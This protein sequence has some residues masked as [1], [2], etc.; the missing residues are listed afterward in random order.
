MK[1]PKKDSIFVLCCVVVLCVSFIFALWIKQGINKMAQAK[2]Y[3]IA[4]VKSKAPVVQR[5][6][7]SWIASEERVME[8]T[9]IDNDNTVRGQFVM[10]DNS[11]LGNIGRGNISTGRGFGRGNVT[12]TSVGATAVDDPSG[13]LLQNVEASGRASRFNLQQG[14]IVISINGQTVTGAESFD[15]LISAIGQGAAISMQVI[16][17]GQEITVGRDTVTSVTGRMGRGG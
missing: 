14:D 4:A 12:S 1:P 11:M 16:R 2:A 15:T 3:L 17:N 9:Y 5:E 6:P 10:P 7:V 8:Q 13:A